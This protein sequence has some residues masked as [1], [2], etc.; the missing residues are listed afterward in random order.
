MSTENKQ[1]SR[2]VS[3]EVL[4]ATTIIKEGAVKAAVRK[5]SLEERPHSNRMQEVAAVMDEKSNKTASDVV[6]PAP[7][8]GINKNAEQSA[9]VAKDL[10]AKI[11]ENSAQSAA[12]ASSSSASGGSSQPV[13]RD[14]VLSD[15]LLALKEACQSLCVEHNDLVGVEFSTIKT[16]LLEPVQEERKRVQRLVLEVEG[17]IAALQ[18]ILDPQ[19]MG[20]KIKDKEKK[21][22]EEVLK[23]QRGRKSVIEEGFRKLCEKEKIIEGFKES[24]EL[25]QYLIEQDSGGERTL[26][27]NLKDKGF[28]NVVLKIP[29]LSIPVR[30]GLSEFLGDLQGGQDNGV[31]S[32]N[33]L[34]ERFQR[35]TLGMLLID[36]GRVKTYIRS[37]GAAHEDAETL[38]FLFQVFLPA[39]MAV[40]MTKMIPENLRE[41]A[42]KCGNQQK[43]EDLAVMQLALHSMKL[44]ADAPLNLQGAFKNLDTVLSLY[45]DRPSDGYTKPRTVSAAV[46]GVSGNMHS[47]FANPA[48]SKGESGAVPGARVAPA[49][50]GSAPANAFPQSS[51][52]PALASLPQ[53]SPNK[54]IYLEPPSDER[55]FTTIENFLNKV[56]TRIDPEEGEFGLLESEALSYKDLAQAAFVLEKRLSEKNKVKE[57]VIVPQVV[58]HNSGLEKM[59]FCTDQ[60]SLERCILEK[61]HARSEAQKKIQPIELYIKPQLEQYLKYPHTSSPGLAIA[62]LKQT[63]GPV[64]VYMPLLVG[65]CHWAFLCIEKAENGTINVQ[66]KDSYRKGYHCMQPAFQKQLMDCL[67]FAG[68]KLEGDTLPVEVVQPQQG[69]GTSCGYAGLLHIGRHERHCLWEG[70]LQGI[71]NVPV[72]TLEQRQDRS[73]KIKAFVAR[74]LGDL[75]SERLKMCFLDKSDPRCVAF[76]NNVRLE[77]RKKKF[78]DLSKAVRSIFQPITDNTKKV[79]QQIQSI[80]FALIEDPATFDMKSLK[81]EGLEDF[82]KFDDLLL[83]KTVLSLESV[84]DLSYYYFAQHSK[85][86]SIPDEKDIFYDNSRVAAKWGLLRKD[87]NQTFKA[88]CYSALHTEPNRLIQSQRTVLLQ[89]VEELLAA[90]KWALPKHR[91][92]RAYILE[93]RAQAAAQQ[94]SEQVDPAE[95]EAKARAKVVRD[96]AAEWGADIMRRLKKCP[97]EERVNDEENQDNGWSNN[98]NPPSLR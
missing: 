37:L 73:S 20:Q 61:A 23:E 49:A 29:V 4:D 6:Q 21:S 13:T 34:F 46:P 53:S 57:V 60:T 43:V 88:Q 90:L 81:Q 97:S 59:Y 84:I 50:L 80:F 55:Y 30:T 2:N 76:R 8:T 26:E 35:S 51:V 39:L 86:E 5:L 66:M 24:M 91:P 32:G 11:N 72:Q 52:S 56:E 98:P 10:Q 9:A 89:K 17:R 82:N 12:R 1:E 22:L 36:F 78:I 95:A 27:K 28:R 77:S 70:K 93:L 16:E 65:G 85:E 33:K 87:F 14:T 94:Q 75:W 69:D 48:G 63:E 42:V 44:P 71:D 19:I 41:L 83:Y 45:T 58:F 79:E 62:W 31:A 68:L 67:R 38:R 54:E 96:K 25:V 74:E 3:G 40:I 92:I 15:E 18:Q 47:V 64:S 7:Q